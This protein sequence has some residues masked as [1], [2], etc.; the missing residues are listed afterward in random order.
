[1]QEKIIRKGNKKLFVIYCWDLVW[2]LDA[3][4]QE[5]AFYISKNFIFSV[6]TG[7]KIHHFTSAMPLATYVT[8]PCP[9]A[10]IHLYLT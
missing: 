5:E 10:L 4:A 2:L 3:G 8:N 6:F 9:R 7:I 1:M